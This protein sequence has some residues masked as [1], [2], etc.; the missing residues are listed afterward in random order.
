MLER[1][2]GFAGTSDQICYIRRDD[3][4]CYY[5]RCKGSCNRG[6]VLL[7]W[8]TNFTASVTAG[9]HGRQHGLPQ[10][11]KG[12]YNH[13][14]KSWNRCPVEL[15]GDP[16]EAGMLQPLS[17]VLEPRCSGAARGGGELLIFW[18]DA[19]VDRWS[20][21]GAGTSPTERRRRCSS[22]LRWSPPAVL[23]LSINDDGNARRKSCIHSTTTGARWRGRPTRMSAAPRAVGEHGRR[24][25]KRGVT[26]LMSSR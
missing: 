10:P 25:G 23:E 1:A 24:R 3:Q 12:S 19:T 2:S 22:E 8:A 6:F 20:E 17:G 13:G 9:R 16:P 15:Q 21:I 14:H 18:D 26:P 7:L 11:D 4:F 5:E